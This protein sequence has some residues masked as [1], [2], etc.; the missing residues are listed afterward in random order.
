MIGDIKYCKKCKRVVIKVGSKSGY[1]CY[2][3]GE[4]T[5]DE[6]ESKNK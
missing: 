4:V 2:W 1:Y 3:C 6:V 5:K